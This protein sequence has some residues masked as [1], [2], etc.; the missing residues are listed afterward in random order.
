[1]QHDRAARALAGEIYDTVIA[2]SPVESSLIGDRRFDATLP[3]LSHDGHA[4]LSAILER[5][6]GKVERI[7]V[8]ALSPDDRVTVDVAGHVIDHARHE[9]SAG[10]VQFAAGPM[11]SGA[12]V[13]S[14]ASA[15]LINLPKLTL[16][17]PEQADAYVERCRRIPGHLRDAEAQ[18]L[19]G[20]ATGR[21][22]VARLVAAT[23]RQLD[24]YLAIPEDSDPL[25]LMPDAP[26][27]WHAALRTVLAGEVRPAMAGH[28]AGLADRIAP[29]ARADEHAGLC[30]LAGG[31]QIYRDAIRLHT[32]TASTPLELHQLGLDLI[33]QLAGEY[34]E[35]GGR[36]LQAT[37]LNEIFERLRTAPALRFEAAHEI[38]AAAE[39]A[40]ARAQAAVGDWFATPTG[41]ACEVREIPPVEAPESTLAYYQPPAIDGS[42]PGR[43]FVNTSDPTSRTR[44][45]AE[46]LAFH[47]SVPGHHTQIARALELDLPTLQ[48]VFY[49][50]AFVE[51]W[52]LYTERLADE[53]GLYSNDL[54]R[55][56][57]LSFDSWRACRLV[58]DTGLHALGWPRERAVE[59][60]RANSPQA[61]NNINNEVDR[62]IGWPGQALAY[63]A[64]RTRIVELRR[65]A[66]RVLGSRFDLPAFH[67]ALLEHAAVPLWTLERL[68]D[69]WIS[70]QS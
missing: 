68:V 67:D 30:W 38:R 40:L 41:T 61:L 29:R 33:E 18:L 58:V 60:M 53:M 11:T 62:Y 69:D 31:D 43:Y 42:R 64:G 66:E 52:A 14:A 34:R 9:L 50:T 6:S 4:A 10:Y 26:A 23:I 39:A 20:V 17:T 15:L 2:A 44:F 57:M 1:L 46:A 28:R 12:T 55:L 51:G 24:R 59:F 37:S 35:L 54:A 36:V 8:S 49:A 25:L 21:G 56:G 16:D 47:E 22:P 7:D 32:T 27:D 70:R 63:M 3:D 48:R 19:D 65:R 5:L 13:G 45:E